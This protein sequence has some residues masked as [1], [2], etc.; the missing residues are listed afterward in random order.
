LGS[1]ISVG[2]RLHAIEADRTGWRC[3]QRRDVASGGLRV[4]DGLCERCEWIGVVRGSGSGRCDAMRYLLLSLIVA[5]LRCDWLNGCA[6]LPVEYRPVAIDGM[7]LSR[8]RAEGA[9]RAV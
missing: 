1:G 7:A 8:S 3:R 4:S 6:G 5:F 2:A 9:G